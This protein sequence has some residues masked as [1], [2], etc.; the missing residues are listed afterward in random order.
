M[1]ASPHWLPV[2]IEGV[3]F[4]SLFAVIGR[5]LRQTGRSPMALTYGDDLAGLSGR[6]LRVLVA[7]AVVISA[8]HAAG[9]DMLA[10]MAGRI[11]ALDHPAVAWAGNVLLAAGGAL[12]THS[13]LTMGPSWLIGIPA[14]QKTPLVVTGVYRLSRNPIYLGLM[15]AITGFV[16]AVPNALTAAVAAAALVGL[17]FQVRMEE[18]HLRAAFGASYE[19]YRKTVRRWL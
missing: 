1:I 19:D 18:R 5:F 17:S 12:F 4:L 9:P 10:G 13:Q 8:L 15:I 16:L 14:E 2:A 11:A 7:A 3:I 6:I